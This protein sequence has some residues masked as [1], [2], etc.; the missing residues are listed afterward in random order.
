MSA[1]ANT[2]VEVIAV[3]PCPSRAIGEKMR[4]LRI[5]DIRYCDVRIP[6]RRTSSLVKP[7]PAGARDSPRS[8]IS[9]AAHPLALIIFFLPD[10]RSPAVPPAGRVWAVFVSG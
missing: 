8:A 2:T 6:S 4:Q 5:A 10:A 7:P 1:C 9:P 3:I